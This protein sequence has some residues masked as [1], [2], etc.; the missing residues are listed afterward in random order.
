M[1][2]KCRISNRIFAGCQTYQTAASLTTKWRALRRRLF[3]SE[4]SNDMQNQ[5]KE[6]AY[7]LNVGNIFLAERL[8]YS[9][10]TGLIIFF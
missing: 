3:L 10:I 4:S 7:L 2:K 5:L 1:P 6:G 8:L 9:R